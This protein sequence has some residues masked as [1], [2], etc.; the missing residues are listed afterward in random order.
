MDA[1]HGRDMQSE[2][3]YLEDADGKKLRSPRKNGRS[4]RDMNGNNAAWQRKVPLAVTSTWNQSSE[5]KSFCSNGATITPR[6]YA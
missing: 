1:M 2:N 6:E 4:S 3:D 5:V